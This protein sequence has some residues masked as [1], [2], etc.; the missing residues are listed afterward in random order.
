MLFFKRTSNTKRV[1]SLIVLLNN[2]RP[3]AGCDVIP[4]E[5]PNVNN[6]YTVYIKN[7]GL[8]FTYL[9]D[10]KKAKYMMGT[11]LNTPLFQNKPYLY[12]K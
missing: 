11:I 6:P 10:G 12:Q 1:L 5:M 9:D 3:V 7:D 8:Y 4:T 2:N